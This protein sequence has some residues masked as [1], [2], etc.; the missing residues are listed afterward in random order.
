MGQKLRGL[1]PGSKQ[2]T[3]TGYRIG[4]RVIVL[5]GQVQMPAAGFQ[6]S[7]Q[8][9]PRDYPFLGTARRQGEGSSP[10]LSPQGLGQGK[11]KHTTVGEGTAHTGVEGTG[12]EG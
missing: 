11:L 9:P 3:G 7:L 2:W 4:H 6:A 8:S 12:D 5:N 10:T 1:A